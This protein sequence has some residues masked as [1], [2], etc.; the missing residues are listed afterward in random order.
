[1]LLIKVFPLNIRTPL[2]KKT[3]YHG[4]IN[5]DFPWH[6][7]YPKNQ[8]VTL[9]ELVVSHSYDMI[10]FITVLEK[11]SILIKTQITEQRI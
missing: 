3:L 2:L 1:M 11:K 9:E 6:L 10:T 7:N 4:S 5:K 8:I